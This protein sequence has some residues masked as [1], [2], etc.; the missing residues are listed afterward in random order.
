MVGFQQNV[1]LLTK[2]TSK[3]C[4]FFRSKRIKVWIFLV[5][6]GR[7]NLKKKIISSV[8]LLDVLE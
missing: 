7:V 6:K 4:T 5:E 3:I 1:E 2:Q 8:L